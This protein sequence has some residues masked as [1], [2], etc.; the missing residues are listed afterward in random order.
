MALEISSPLIDFVTQLI[1]STGY[2]GLFVLMVLESMAAPIPS[3]LVMPFA[4]FLVVDGKFDLLLVVVV[5]S[6]ASL[7]GSLLS[8]YIACFG[9]KE[10]IHRYGKFFLLNREHLDKTEQ[11]FKKRGNATI[12]ISRFIP[13]VRHLISLPAGLG[14]MAIKKF[15]IY[16]LIGATIWNTFLLWVGM[17]LRERWEIIHKYTS[18]LD[19]LV[20][21]GIV[22]TVLF[23]LRPHIKKRWKLYLPD[24]IT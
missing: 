3:E 17:Q 18:L 21:I 16:T 7:T 14:R 11:W 15:I 13:V 22:A 19:I 4:G 9:E 20:V 1:S 2:A 8:Y 12:L 23:Y 6:L 5:T 10:L 24:A